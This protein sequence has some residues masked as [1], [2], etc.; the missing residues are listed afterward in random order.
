MREK[1]GNKGKKDKMRI[2]KAARMPR[3]LACLDALKTRPKRKTKSK[4]PTWNWKYY[5]WHDLN[6]KGVVKCILCGK[7]VHAGTRRLKQHLGG[8]DEV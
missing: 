8:Y 3:V 2:G 7:I 1:G 4:D 6:K 5:Y